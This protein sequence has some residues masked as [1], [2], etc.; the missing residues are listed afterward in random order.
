[1]NQLAQFKEAMNT[2]CHEAAEIVEKYCGQ[3]LDKRLRQGGSITR[4]EAEKFGWYAIKK[5]RLELAERARR[6]GK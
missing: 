6:H 1:M 3:W 5:M 4:E 2:H